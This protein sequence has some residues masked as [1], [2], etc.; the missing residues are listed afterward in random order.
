[1]REIDINDLPKYSPWVARLLQLEHFQKQERNLTKIEAEYN[2]DK[3]AKL[4]DQ[5]EAKKFATA[6]E[7]RALERSSSQYEI[8]VSRGNKLFIT[9]PTDCQQIE[10]EMLVDALADP[11]STAKTIVELGCGYGYNFAVLKERFANRT[12]LG[13]EYSANAI[14]LGNRLF[15]SDTDVS[16]TFFN[17]YDSEW[18][19]L[20]NI[21]DTALI[22]TRHS[23]EQLPQARNILSAFAKYR[24]KITAVVHLEPVYELTDN[25]TLGLMR[26][27]YT[28]LNDYNID[29][30][31][32]VKHMGLN[33]R[34]IHYDIFGSNPLNPTSLISWQF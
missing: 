11:I 16:I 1:M 12:W 31:S 8:C 5:Y 13:G 33:I 18:P 3:Y 28:H 14:T 20:E 25:S 27:A 34:R 21:K 30:L 9:T 23:I 15:S 7:Q 32:M 29:L 19:I 2:K 6:H 22:F 26:R 4:L 24:D 17:W 10:D